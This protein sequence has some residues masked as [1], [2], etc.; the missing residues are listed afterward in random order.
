MVFNMEVNS[1]Y[2]CQNKEQLTKY[3]HSALGSHPKTTLIEAANAKYLRGCK[4][5]DATA[6]RKY[7]DVEE[8]TEMGHMNQIQQGYRSTT[9]VSN[10]GWPSKLV[11]AIQ[12]GSRA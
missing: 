1:I 3:Y 11:A 9:K 4:G 6:I 7:I 5:L 12:V 2:E 10:K 8:A